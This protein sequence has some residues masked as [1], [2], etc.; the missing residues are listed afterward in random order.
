MKTISITAGSEAAVSEHFPFKEPRP[1]Q[2]VAIRAISNAWEEGHKYVFLEAPTGF[3]KSAIAITL[4][5]ERPNA[6]ILVSTKTL[7]KQYV[8]EELYKTIDVRGRSNFTCTQVETRTCDEGLCQG[9]FECEYRPRRAND[10]IP[11]PANAIT[12]VETPR[13]ILWKEPGSTL[14]RYWDQKCRAMNH[15]YPILNYSYFLHETF[16]AGDFQKR[17]RLIC[18][19]AHN[20]ED[21]LMKFISFSMSDNDLKVVGCRIPKNDISISEW[22]ESIKDWQE[23]FELELKNVREVTEDSDE[24]KKD[25]EII[26]KIKRLSEKID[27]CK[28]TIEELSE[29]KENWIIDNVVENSIRK[30]TFKPIFVKKWANRFFDKAELFLLQSAT[31][32]DANAMAESLGLP[33]KECLFIKAPSDFEPEK[34][35][36]YY[37]PV[38]KM[39]REHIDKSLLSLIEEIKKLMKKYPKDKGVIHTHTYKIQNFILNNIESNRLIA[40]RPEELKKRDAIIRKFMGSVRPMILVTPSAFEGMDF[41]Y[42]TCRWQVLC[43]IPYPSMGDK[44]VKKRMGLDPHWYQWKTVLRLVQT[45]GRGMRAKDDWCDTYIFDSSFSYFQSR[46]RELFPGWFT[47]ALR[48]IS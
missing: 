36:I 24:K 34:R 37:K 47:E 32:I 11:L 48:N 17:N 25:I 2:S 44:Q 29:N 21:S 22:V 19:E 39:S 30:V 20:I 1:M 4:A 23:N 10:E 33:E 13:D 38:G 27:K 41:K 18:D 3:G 31:I 45:Y 12:I 26:N 5:R 35:P 43:K 42:N 9:G 46:N 6:F 14:C 28:F 7:Q 15:K 40:N 8:T 16:H